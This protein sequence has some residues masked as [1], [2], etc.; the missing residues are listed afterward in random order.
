MRETE[1]GMPEFGGKYMYRATMHF[2]RTKYPE[3]YYEWNDKVA[4][5]VEWMEPSRLDARDEQ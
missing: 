2:L 5:A 1:M 3:I 4:Y